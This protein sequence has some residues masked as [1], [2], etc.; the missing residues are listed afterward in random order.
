MNS[1][2]LSWILNRHASQGGVTEIR[3]IRDAKD[4]R[5]RWYRYCVPGQLNNMLA[6]LAMLPTGPRPRLGHGVHPR[7]GEA[8]IYFTLNPV[9]PNAEGL[10]L[11]RDLLPG[12]RATSDTDILAYSLMLIDVDPVRPRGVS[13]TK[14][15]KSK[16][17][18]VIGRIQE[19]LHEYNVR[20][21]LGDSGNGYH[22]LIPL[23]PLPGTR[24]AARDA[25]DFLKLLDQRFSSEGAKVDTSTFNPSR[26]CKLYGTL[27]IKGPHSEN[28]PH[29]LSSIM[30][31]SSTVDVPLFELVRGELEAF[32]RAELEKLKKVQAPGRAPLPA[33]RQQMPTDSSWHE[34]RKAAVA[35]IPLDA[36]Y[37]QYLTGHERAGWLECRDPL[38]ESGDKNPS[39]GVAD[40]TRDAE[41]GAF[42]SFR[43]GKTLSVFDALIE[44]FGLADMKAAVQRVAELS[45]IPRPVRRPGA[46]PTPLDEEA[47]PAQS[48]TPE[49]PPTADP[50]TFLDRFCAAWGGANNSAKLAILDEFLDELLLVPV[51]LR[52]NFRVE[53]QRLA[54]LDTADLQELLKQARAR[55]RARVK[56][57][58]EPDDRALGVVKWV[59]NLDPVN[60]LFST[61]LDRLNAH[62]RFFQFGPGL[63]FVRPGI[64]P[65]TVTPENL[66]GLMTGFFE[67]QVLRQNKEGD[68]I[69]QRFDVFP[70]TQAKALLTNPLLTERVPECNSYCRVPFFD[71]EWRW[72]GRPGWHPTAGVYYDGPE[73]LP[74]GVP[75]FTLE[76]SLVDRMLS[77]FAFQSPA[78]RANF[79]GA[80]LTAITWP[81]WT[82]GHAMVAINGNRPGTGKTTLAMLLAIVADG[83]EVET[84]TFTA[85]DEELEKRLGTRVESGSHVVII[86][87]VK[88]RGALESQ[89]L[90]RVV[91]AARPSF[92]RLQTNTEIMRPVND[93]LFVLTMNGTRLGAD[94]RRRSLPINLHLNQD[95]TDRSFTQDQ[96]LNWVKANRPAIVA[97]LAGMVMA[98]LQAGRPRPQSPAKHSTSN[99]WATTIDAILAHSGRGR[100]L[101]G[102]E[103]A[104][105]AFD[106]NHEWMSEVA[107]A[108]VAAEHCPAYTD[109]WVSR[110]ELAGL[111]ERFKDKN[112]RDRTPRAKATI[113]GALFNEYAGKTFTYPEGSIKLTQDFP[114]GPTAKP[115]YSFTIISV[116][117]HAREGHAMEGTD[118]GNQ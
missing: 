16:A 52:K 90:E 8:N 99:A 105:A 27:A 58:V 19:W 83:R 7:N 108:M 96:L 114:R 115:L 69:F 65:L 2:F 110:I 77:D 5:G 63:I 32:R 56:A 84:C 41:R 107:R 29:R 101:D 95:P 57:P 68:L 25:Q 10:E 44:L 59:Q 46:A 17:L 13:A 11:H 48:E 40:G 18:D 85:N 14:E 112:G 79:I 64:G 23:V 12:N 35:A 37:G 61:V 60:T 6:T 75:V 71:A 33:S 80:L 93:I 24:L 109:A 82:D 15:E 86:D 116:T 74:G 78:D 22:L 54:G 73:I 118:D 50:E 72:I 66:P 87:N 98:W 103:A 36:I 43:T 45:G 34:W 55:L 92:R 91:T 4:Q 51:F 104:M 94:L 39:A 53:L 30:L 49:P 111:A 89:V 20:P 9:N 28:R 106:P 21:L 97:E 38:S 70:A 1:E 102:Y 88:T 47:A 42:H 67:L 76:G 113:L 26:I 117:P 62:Q 100:F 81:S 3:I 31:P